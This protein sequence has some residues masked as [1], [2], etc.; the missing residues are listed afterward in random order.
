MIGIDVVSVERIDMTNKR[1]I[2]MVLTEDERREL[3]LYSADSRRKEYIAGR[4]AAKEA[5]FKAT[6]DRDYLKYAI[7][8]ETSGRPYVK[9]HPE[10]SV[11]ISHDGGIAAAIVQIQAK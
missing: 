3:A 2:E 1:F 10:I 5:I 4:F 9:D 6:Q 8:H 11:S 7:L